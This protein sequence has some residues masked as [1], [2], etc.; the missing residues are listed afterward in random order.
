[1]KKILGLTGESCRPG[2]KKAGFIEAS[3]VLEQA[4]NMGREI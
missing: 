2:H 1:M 4:E 3:G